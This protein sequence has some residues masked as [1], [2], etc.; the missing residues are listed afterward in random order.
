MIDINPNPTPK[1]PLGTE[2]WY[3]LKKK[4]MNV[5]SPYSQYVKN[6]DQHSNK[7]SSLHTINS[8]SN[9]I[10]GWMK[11]LRGIGDVAASEGQ[12]IK[13]VRFHLNL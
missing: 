6:S 13:K 3:G 10:P 12:T 8:N 9:T 11:E 4:I 7:N 2:F 5:V 1:N